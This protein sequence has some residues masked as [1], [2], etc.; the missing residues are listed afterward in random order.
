MDKEKYIIE[1]FFLPLAK[2]EEALQLQN[3]AALLKKKNL[4]IS[5]DMM[6]EDQHFKKKD[7][8]KILAKKLV[9]INLSDIAAMGAVPYGFFLNLAVPRNNVDE[10]IKRFSL[11]LSEDIKQ[12]DIKLFGGDLSHSS[13]IFLSMTIL[14]KINKICHDNNYSKVGSDI[15]VSGNIGDAP[16][17]FEFSKNFNCFDGPKNKKLKLIN[18]YYIP[19]PRINLGLSLLN[20]VDFCTDISDGLVREISR[21]ASQSKLQANIFLENIPFSSEVKSIINMN[22]KKKIHEIILNGGEDYELLFSSSS[23]NRKKIDK[24]K[25]ITRIGNFS[26]G[27]GLKVFDRKFQNINLKKKGFSHF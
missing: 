13:T 26:N 9:R 22:D 1:N 12:F 8:P 3:D 14:G 6:V 2:N 18:K 27:R 16:L 11:G 4:V 24:I 7:D 15:Y 20:K 10:W 25:N 23:N 21:V 5:T 19:E 17:G